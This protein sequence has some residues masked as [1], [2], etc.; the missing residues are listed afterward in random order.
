VARS[1][2]PEGIEPTDIVFKTQL[3]HPHDLAGDGIH[4]VG[5]GAG[6]TTSA[7]LKAL[8]DVLP[9]QLGNLFDE[10]VFHRFV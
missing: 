8:V 7:T 10:L 5:H 4:V 3:R 1:T 9:A 6:A 2:G